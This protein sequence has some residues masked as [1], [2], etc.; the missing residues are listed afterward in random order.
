MVVPNAPRDPDG[1][2]GLPRGPRRALLQRLR[3][4]VA[5]AGDGVVGE[6]GLA[7]SV[8]GTWVLV[9]ID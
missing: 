4:Q 3:A 5:H 6:H 2:A 9:T 8:V 1:G 7:R